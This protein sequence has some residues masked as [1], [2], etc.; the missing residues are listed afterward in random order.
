MFGMSN[1][2]SLVMSAFI[3]LPIVIFLREMSYLLVSWL[4]GVNNPRLTIGSGPRLFKIGIIDI[5]KYY[6]VYSWFSYDELKTDSKI[7]YILV[8]ASPIFINLSIAL[9]INFL[10]ANGWGEEY[11]TFWTALFFMLFILFYL[12]SFL[13]VQ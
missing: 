5:R 2:V 7:A 13:C 10:L 12:T 1:L 6:H 11:K 9:L 4:F 8:Y 3:I